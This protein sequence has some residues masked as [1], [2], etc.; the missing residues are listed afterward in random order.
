MRLLF[1]SILFLIIFNYLG[2]TENN[3]KIKLLKK[4]SNQPFQTDTATIF[5]PDV[6]SNEFN[7]RDASLSPDENEFFYS[8]R[9][10]SFFSIIQVKKVNGIW[11]NPEVAPFSGKYSDL[12]PMFS[13]DGKKLFFVSNR[14]VAGNDKPKDYD[15][16]F[17]EKRNNGWGPPQNIGKPINTESN[18]FYPSFAKDGSMYFCATYENGLGGEDLY[19]SKFKNGKFLQP[20]NMGDSINTNRDEYNSFVSPDERYIIYTSLGWGRGIGGGDLWIS[21]RKKDQ[22]WSKPK[23]LGEKVNTS[24]FEYCPTITHNGK[25]L[26]FTSN[27]SNSKN[28]SSSLLNY[29]QIITSLR[30]PLNGSQNIYWI[31]TD[32]IDS[33]KM[34]VL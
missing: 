26:F 4:L 3:Q 11:Q 16:W 30:S 32:F 18:E 25:Y 10:T 12:E 17:V 1:W 9:G 6:I 34:D 31:S 22:S 27:R 19:Y 13:Q 15:I 14:P 33:L 24:F 5:L 2:C 7:V 8:L 29:N 20:I 21:F 23:N 28:Y